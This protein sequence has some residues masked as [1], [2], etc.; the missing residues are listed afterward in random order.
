MTHI[1][2]PIRLFELIDLLDQT[3]FTLHEDPRGLTRSV[4][5]SDVLL[6]Q[7]VLQK[8]LILLVFRVLIVVNFIPQ[9]D[10]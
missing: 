9:E 10:G 1:I 7:V 5:G 6:C 3:T 2:F 8:V 4:G